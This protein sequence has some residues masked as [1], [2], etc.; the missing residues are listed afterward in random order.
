[1][2]GGP[3]T[4]PRHGT[5]V[6][7]AGR[8]V[9]I[10]GASGAGKTTLALELIRRARHADITAGL[11]ADDRVDITTGADGP[12][13]RCPEPIAGRIEVRG[14]G[15]ADARRFVAE[16]TPIQ[17][18]AELVA[19]ADAR[20]FHDG[21]TFDLGGYRVAHLRLPAGPGVSAAGAVFCAIGLPAWI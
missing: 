7:L 19:P 18:V 21:E 2:T 1:M 5:A 13:A 4:N 10:T 17:L 11:I 9:L 16:P 14:F 8:G 20:R 3:A 6:M 15:V 12:V